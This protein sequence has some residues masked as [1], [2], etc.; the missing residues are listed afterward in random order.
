[1]TENGMGNWECGLR[2]LMSRD[3]ETNLFVDNRVSIV[4]RTATKS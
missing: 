3:Q 1:M 2:K 4:K